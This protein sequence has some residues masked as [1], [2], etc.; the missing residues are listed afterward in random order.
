MQR[1][2]FW[3]MMCCPW[4]TLSLPGHT[5]RGNG[6]AGYPVC[7]SLPRD[8]AGMAWAYRMAERHKQAQNDNLQNIENHAFETARLT[9]PCNEEKVE[10]MAK[11]AVKNLE[12]KVAVVNKNNIKPVKRNA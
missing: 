1:T 10:K 3:H 4:H 11:T 9:A 6:K 8:G 2:T 12:R 5:E 7:F